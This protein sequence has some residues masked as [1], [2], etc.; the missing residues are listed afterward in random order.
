MPR[1]VHIFVDPYSEIIA[2]RHTFI[3]AETKITHTMMMIVVYGHFCA[4][5]RLNG[6]SDLQR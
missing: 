4:R 6:P 2:E 3:V 1:I 5:G